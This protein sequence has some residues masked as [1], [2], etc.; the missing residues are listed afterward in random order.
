MRKKLVLS[1]ALSCA[2][3]FFGGCAAKRDSLGADFGK[4]DYRKIDKPVYEIYVD[5][6]VE[7]TEVSGNHDTGRYKADFTFGGGFL[8]DV[9]RI[10][11][12]P[13]VVEE[14]A[15]YR[16]LPDMRLGKR[17]LSEIC[18]EIA[19]ESGTYWSY[20]KGTIRFFTEKT[21][22]YKL[23]SITPARL[24]AVYNISDDKDV[25]D[26][27][28]VKSDLFDEIE[29]AL[30]VVIDSTVLSGEIRNSI[31][32]KRENA[33]TVFGANEKTDSRENGTNVRETSGVENGN[34]ERNLKSDTGTEKKENRTDT[35]N[36]RGMKSSKAS[37]SS[38][39]KKNASDI[40]VVPKVEPVLKDVETMAKKVKNL[41]EYNTMFQE[42]SRK[43]SRESSTSEKIAT[44]SGKYEGRSGSKRN[45][46]EETKSREVYD[47]VREINS[48]RKRYALLKE[49]GVIVVSVTKENEAKVD[50]V[51]RSI[52]KS[53]LSNMVMLDA[54]VLDVTDEKLHEFSAKFDS[55]ILKNW[56]RTTI[57]TAKNVIGY[58]YRNTQP[59]LN[60]FKIS[61]LI[62]FLTGNNDSKILQEPKILTLPNVP[63]RLKATIDYPYLEPQQVSVGGTEPQLS[64]NIKYVSD[65]IDMAVMANVMGDTIFLNLGLRINQYLGRETFSAGQLGTFDLPLQSPR[66]LNTSF[67]VKPGDV[68]FI[69]GL[70][71]TS[72]LDKRD[73]NFLVP[74]GVRKEVSKRNLVIVAVPKLIR[75]VERKEK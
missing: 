43:E 42:G 70:S 39:K 75:F 13:V 61:A 49:A 3:L 32:R 23:P 15:A 12:I 19:K 17:K 55:L 30:S 21:V 27:D 40:R 1:A 58:T 41:K 9:G 4:I 54:Y 57:D 22:I 51:I 2:L 68:V 10:G 62:G 14:E 5:S 44:V 20:D 28:K 11:K 16:L 73:S 47:V 46:N 7:K 74:T 25:F 8:K 60:D 69:G 37:R 56:G 50:A 18:D 35:E 67:R 29:K 72:R 36:E 31:E 45:V 33:R 65:G 59:N 66:V 26:V 52:V 48:K 6:L 24:Q 53:A 34:T 64:Y 38:R 71:K 63:S